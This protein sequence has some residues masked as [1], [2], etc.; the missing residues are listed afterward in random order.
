MY[1]RMKFVLFFRFFDSCY[2]IKYLLTET[3]GK[4][5]V[6]FVDPRLSVLPSAS[7]QETSTVS[8]PQ[9]IL[10]PSVSVNKCYSN[11]SITGLSC[12]GNMRQLLAWGQLFKAGLALI[13]G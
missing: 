5:A 9:N 8:G 13:L 1:F 4:H 11:Y 12:A 6:C 3:S 7:P 2:I 10:F